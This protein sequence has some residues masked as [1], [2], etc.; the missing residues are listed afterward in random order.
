MAQYC[1]ERASEIGTVDKSQAQRWF[2]TDES[3]LMAESNALLEGGW[4]L[5]EQMGVG[6]TYFFKTYTKCLVRRSLD[7][8]WLDLRLYRIS[9][10]L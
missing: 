9:F 6:K 7:F 3:Q 10:N 1:D 8:S 2:P 4:T 5:G